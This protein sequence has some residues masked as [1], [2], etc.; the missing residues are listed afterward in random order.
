MI[1]RFG[2]R[3]FFCFKE[4]IDIDFSLNSDVPLEISMGRDFATVMGIKGANG[5]GKTNVIKAI[6]FISN[7]CT[8]SADLD[9]DSKIDLDSYFRNEDPV[10]FYIEFRFEKREY[11]YE[12]SLT[13]KNV[14]SEILYRERGK[15]ETKIL[16]RTNDEVVFAVSEL[17]ELKDIQL[18]PNA[19][20]LSQSKK[21]KFR[22]EMEDLNVVNNFFT[23]ILTNVGYLGR[24]D[25][26]LTYNDM[27]ENY[28]ENPESFDLVKKIIVASDDGIED[29]KILSRKNEDGEDIS[30]PIFIHK[31][32]D[33]S[34]FL[35][36]YDESSGTKSLFK[37]MYM[38]WLV[39]STGGVLAL[40]EFDIHLHSLIL[41]KIV[42][43][44]NDEQSNPKEAQFIFTA[45]NTEIIDKL[46][47]Y[48][49][50]LVSKEDNESFCY[51]LDE[52]P[53][54]MISSDEKISPLYL[55]GKLGGVPRV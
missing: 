46:S 53:G 20:V 26:S 47:I 36:I 27:A 51:R 31:S 11:R 14:V 34:H 43:L 44:F 1:I 38:Y 50:I 48:R 41:P 9:L 17:G 8:K 42:D 2:V 3:N 18:R 55:K 30:Y 25:F 19:S 40:D 49:T 29:I 45:H 12:L 33:K 39:L 13:N 35:T 23:F 4:G 15:R 16:E 22:S 10:D 6:D 52:V 24:S 37:M 28:K 54:G 32:E 5:S 7:F 21:Y